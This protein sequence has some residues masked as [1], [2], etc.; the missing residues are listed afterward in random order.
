M[1]IDLLLL[2]ITYIYI[3]T[4]MDTYTYILIYSYIY[5]CIYMYTSIYIYIYIYTCIHTII[6]IH[7]YKHTHKHSYIQTRGVSLVSYRWCGSCQIGL[8]DVNMIY[9]GHIYNYIWF[10]PICVPYIRHI[11]DMVQVL[12]VCVCMCVR[13]FLCHYWCTRQNNTCM[14]T[15]RIL[16]DEMTYC[17]TYMNIIRFT[18]CRYF[19]IGLSSACASDLQ[20]VCVYVCVYVYVY[21]CVYVYVYLHICT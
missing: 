18:W 14:Y 13:M 2:C 9:E 6:Y 1:W 8:Y 7:T 12:C 19:Q 11:R 16:Y 17:V 4:Y 3:Y 20:Q 21:V 15:C 10:N 5:I